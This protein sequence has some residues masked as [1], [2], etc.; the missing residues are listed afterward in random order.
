MS[1]TMLTVGR[2]WKSMT[3]AQRVAA[4][5]A[6]WRDEAFDE[7]ALPVLTDHAADEYRFAAR[8]DAVG[9]TPRLR[10][11]RGLQHGVGRFGHYCIP[12]PVIRSGDSGCFRATSTDLDDRDKRA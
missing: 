2:L 3:P 4:A 8:A 5:L 6:F 1:E 9:E 11:S 7:A 10:P 12:L